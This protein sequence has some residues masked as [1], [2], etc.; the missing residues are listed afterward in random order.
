MHWLLI[1]VLIAAPAWWLRDRPDL[2]AKTYRYTGKYTLVRTYPNG[3]YLIRVNDRLIVVSSD[4][5]PL[6]KTGVLTNDGFE[7]R[8]RVD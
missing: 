7:T 8:L 3:K 5:K 6:T 4:L 2:N 1:G